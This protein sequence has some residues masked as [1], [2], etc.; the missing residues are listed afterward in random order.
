VSL[1][2]RHFAGSRA[3]ICGRLERLAYERAARD[4]VELVELGYYFDDAEADRGVEFFESNLRHHQG[5]WA[6]VPFKLQDW[7]RFIVREVLGWFKPDGTRRFM[8]CYVEVPRKN[9]KTETAAGMALYFLLPDAEDGAQIFSVATKKDQA[10][11]C[12]DAAVQ[13]VKRSPDLTD[14]LQLLRNNI[15]NSELNSKFEP[16]GS[17]ADTLDGLNPH[18]VVVDELHAHRDRKVW[19][20]M[21]TAMGAREEP[22]L[23]AI[24]TAGIYDPESIGW[25]IHQDGVNVLERAIEDI[26][27]FS[28]IAAMDDDDDWREPETW[29]RANPNFGISVKP[30]YL[31]NLAA[32]AK[33]TPSFVNTF[34]RLN[35]NRWTQQAVRWLSME[36]WNAC[37]EPRPLAELRG[38]P[39]YGGLDLSSKL[40]LSCLTL[41]W[42]DG[43]DVDVHL[44]AW[45]PE[46]TIMKRSEHDR[47][48]YD[49]WV[50]DGWL[51]ATPGNVVDYDW[52]EAEIERLNVEFKLVEL[53][54]DPWNATQTAIH[55]EAAGVK[56]VEV[57]QGVASLS[58]PSK[59]L[60]KLVVAGRLRHGGNP[61]LRWM[62]NN[63]A[64][65]E[66]ASGNIRPDKDRSS[67]RIDGIVSTIMALS[68]GIQDLYQPSRYDTEGLLWI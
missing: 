4:R 26:H 52:I 25:T 3:D 49:A 67:E 37:V 55:L 63:V 10:R 32:R 66:D 44:W 28:F 5:R 19:D 41:I 7:Q 22:T 61:V 15:S 48:P 46:D 18:A 60:E 43:E 51:N 8:I 1:D 9:G 54:Y 17:D 58:E 6:G 53:A 29:Q 12:F 14:H 57:R 50:R 16:L 47:V 13:M 23:F 59:E 24:T 42:V 38:L 33:R 64:I 40:D 68:R 45:C 31:E 2:W 65:R 34:L 11:I 36:D 20:V 35:L 62:A 39:C 30:G 21:I 27:L 56:T